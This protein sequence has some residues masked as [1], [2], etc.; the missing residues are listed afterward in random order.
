MFFNLKLSNVT[1][2]LILYKGFLKN[3][4]MELEGSLKITLWTV[5]HPSDLRW[6]KTNNKHATEPN[7]NIKKSSSKWKIS[8]YQA[9][10][11]HTS[12]ELKMLYK[13]KNFKHIKLK[14]QLAGGS[15]KLH[16]VPGINYDLS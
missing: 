9:P 15:L 7:L 12:N 5:T 2:I 16:F 13:D 8:F 11:C 10:M 4:V 14:A 1:E 6:T 3:T